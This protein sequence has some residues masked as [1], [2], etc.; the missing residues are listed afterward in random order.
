[1]F[2][3]IEDAIADLKQGKV[4]IVR[5]MRIGKTKEILSV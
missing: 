5:M 1:M 3:S 4:I 2:H